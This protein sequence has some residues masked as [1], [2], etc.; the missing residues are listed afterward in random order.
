MVCGQHLWTNVAI[1]AAPFAIFAAIAF[2][3]H[4]ISG[5]RADS[6]DRG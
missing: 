3:L 1:T 4:R 2:G 5:A 6:R